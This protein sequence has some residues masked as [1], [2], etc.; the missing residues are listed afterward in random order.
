MVV[1]YTCTMHMVGMSDTGRIRE[2]NQDVFLA[3]PDL[4]LAL[5]ADG[6]GGTRAGGV[7]A[8]IAVDAAL[9]HLKGV[10]KREALS[11]QHLGAAV[12]TA[13]ARVV[14][15][16]NAVSSYRG[17]GTTLVLTVLDGIHAHIAHVGDSRAYRLRGRDFVQVTKDHSLVQEWVDAGMISAEEARSAPNRNVIT[18]AIGPHRSVEADVTE[19][20]VAAG[21]TLL[22][23]SD[24]LTGMVDDDQIASTLNDADDLNEASAKLVAAANRAGGTDNITVVL[25]RC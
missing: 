6:M 11:G 15:M 3:R 9:D 17:M 18:R 19:I 21:D 22:M 2:V 5:L 14:G 13:N 20:E 8:E 23:C 25:I 7:A 1:R 24:G 10:L 12:R 4:N 16:A